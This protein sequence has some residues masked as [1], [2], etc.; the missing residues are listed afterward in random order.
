[1][2]KDESLGHTSFYGEWRCMILKKRKRRRQ[3]DTVEKAGEASVRKA[4][5]QVSS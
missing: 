5:R 1:M 4:K 2:V 3:R